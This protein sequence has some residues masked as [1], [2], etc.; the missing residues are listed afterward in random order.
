ML[1]DEES[2][3]RF[4]CQEIL[5]KYRMRLFYKSFPMSSRT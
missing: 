1:N 3:A 4:T 5:Y 2:P